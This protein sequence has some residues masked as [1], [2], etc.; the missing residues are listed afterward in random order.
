VPALRPVVRSRPPQPL[1][2]EVLRS[3]GL[4]PGQQG[5]QPAALAGLCQGPRLLPRVDQPQAGTGLASGP[6]GLLAEAASAISRVTRSLPDANPCPTRRYVHLRSGR[7]TRCHPHAR[8]GPDRTCGPVNRQRVT[9]E[10]RFSHP[11]AGTFGPADSGA[12]PCLSV[13]REAETSRWP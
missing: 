4:P 5:R 2:P 1:P 6:S 8:S 11:P 7:V 9:R 3:A 10:H 13:R 12:Q